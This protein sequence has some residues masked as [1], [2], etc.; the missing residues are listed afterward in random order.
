MIDAVILTEPRYIKDSE[1]EYIHNVFYEDQL[2][3]N[4]L[5]KKGYRAIRLSWDDPD[6]DW[7]QTKSIV[8]RSTWDYFHRFA[9]FF[10]WLEKVS[11][12]TKL[13]NS[14][15]LI[16]WNLDKH[17]LLDLN[18]KGVHIPKTF[19][20]E[21]GETQSLSKI[22]SELNWDEVVLK[23]CISGGGRHTYRFKSKDAESFEAIYNELIQN[24]S[25]MIQ[26]LQKQVLTKGEVSIMMF[27]GIYSHAILKRAK[28]GD[29]RVQDDFGGTIHHYEPSDNEIE[30]AKHCIKACPELP[31]YARV[32]YFWDNN[33]QLALAEL[34]LIEPELWFREHELAS[35]LMAEAIINK[36]NIVE[37]I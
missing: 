7:S 34:E 19:F 13:I 32:D 24:E 37:T 35:D 14:K 16:Y 3:I 1:K 2:V 31:T 27:N 29:F 4:A 30:F 12:V 22:L 8:F 28:P 23:P 15:T 9:E 6:F 33:N 17:Y 18:K 5:T 11:K 20:V 25:L 26:P 36:L 21:K 10:K